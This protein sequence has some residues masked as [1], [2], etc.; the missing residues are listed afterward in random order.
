MT[1]IILSSLL[2]LFSCNSQMNEKKPF[3]NSITEEW[4]ILQSDTSIYDSIQRYHKEIF[5]KNQDSIFFIDYVHDNDSDKMSFGSKEFLL[6]ELMNSENDLTLSEIYYINENFLLFFSLEKYV[7]SSIEPF[8]FLIVNDSIIKSYSSFHLFD[9][10]KYFSFSKT[11]ISFAKANSIGEHTYEI[12]KI[13]VLGKNDTIKS[14]FI[15]E[16]DDSNESIDKFLEK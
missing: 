13:E 6:K 2:L 9:H 10:Q 12:Q 4:E 5:I 7:S 11:K 14:S 8:Y 15:Y 1:K 3:I 16:L